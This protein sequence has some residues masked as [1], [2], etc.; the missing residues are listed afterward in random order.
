[1]I[2]K[3]YIPYCI[4]ADASS[5]CIYSTKTSPVYRGGF[6]CYLAALNLTVFTFMLAVAFGVL[7]S[8]LLPAR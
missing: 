1:M 2:I 4:R 6:L 5:L 8:G 7:F 3:P